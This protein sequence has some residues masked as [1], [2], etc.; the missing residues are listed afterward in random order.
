[1][2]NPE[3]KVAHEGVLEMRTGVKPRETSER[4]SELPMRRPV[5]FDFDWRDELFRGTA[6]DLFLDSATFDGVDRTVADSIRETRGVKAGTHV[7]GVHGA[8][9][10]HRSSTRTANETSVEIEMDV[11]TPSA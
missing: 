1:V 7:D 2:R 5:L 3:A 10:P 4:G 11:G 8:T 9:D 6:R